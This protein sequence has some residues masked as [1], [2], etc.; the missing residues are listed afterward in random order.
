MLPKFKQTKTTPN[1]NVKSSMKC[2]NTYCSNNTVVCS[3]VVVETVVD[4]MAPQ[5]LPWYHY[6]NIVGNIIGTLDITT[7]YTM[8]ISEAP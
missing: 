5:I 7:V 6:G 2:H 8:V 1:S 4:N 3:F